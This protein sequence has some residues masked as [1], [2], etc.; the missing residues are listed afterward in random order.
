MYR[1]EEIVEPFWAE[2]SSAASGRD[3]LAIQNSSVV[4]YTK[5]VVGITN[6]TNR[7]RYNG[8]FCWI[9]DTIFQSVDKKNSLTT[10]ILYSRRA[11]LLLAYVM[12]KN[13]PD[14]KG[15]SGSD[16]A[17]KNMEST[18][19]LARGADWEY[20]Q[21]G[22]KVYW[23]NPQGIFGQYYS[24]VTRVLNLINHPSSINE[25]NVY[26]LTEKGTYLATAFADRISDEQRNLF[27]ESVLQG[28]ILESDLTRLKPFALHIILESSR[29]H[30]IYKDILLAAD[31]R[32]SDPT[33][34][35]RETIKLL[36][37]HL[38]EQNEGIEDPV[39]SFL[40]TNYKRHLN[41][42]TFRNDA[43]TAWYFFEINELL[44]VAYEHFH[45]S[46]LYFIETYPTL[47][48]DKIDELVDL[49]MDE[50]HQEDLFN[51][52]KTLR[53]MSENAKDLQ[54]DVYDL[55]TEMER[56]FRSG[57]LGKCLL[58]ALRTIIQVKVNSSSHLDQLTSFVSLAENNFNRPGNAIQ[59]FNELVTSHLDSS[60]Q[61]VLK[62]ILLNAINLHTFSSYGKTKI[63]QALVHNYMIEDLSIWRL[64]NTEPNRTSPRLRNVLQYLADIGWVR[65]EGKVWT[66]TDSGIQILEQI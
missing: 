58:Y 16:F 32:K 37:T 45:S 56:S 57:E 60:I 4:I 36:L 50:F 2:Y 5:M 15:V 7:I 46:F 31:D 9:F 42:Q 43:A 53:E 30:I 48:N 28:S 1:P 24:G 25:L 55:Y 52:G 12:V 59:L 21:I 35:R 23:Q 17:L 33:F 10:Q 64:R 19:N 14:I 39:G 47:L 18:V 49:T 11:E 41:E 3:P 20:K 65:N 13:Y 61:E 34:N 26:T 63:G 44:H 27:W 51:E 38:F 66:L 62:T 29:E 22:E 6:V 54:Y 40:R 8:F